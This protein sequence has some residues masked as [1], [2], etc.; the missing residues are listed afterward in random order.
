MSV[1]T[2]MVLYDDALMSVIT[3]MVWYDDDIDDTIW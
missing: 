1:I 3:M 2:M